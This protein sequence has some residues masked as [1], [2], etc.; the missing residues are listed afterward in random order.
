MSQDYTQEELSLECDYDRTYI[1]KI[2][3]GSKD[4]SMEA[5][6]RI[7]EVLDVPASVLFE[8]QSEEGPLEEGN[9]FDRAFRNAD[10][11]IL[12]TDPSGQI[13]QINETTLGFTGFSRDDLVGN[14]VLETSLWQDYET[15]SVMIEQGIQQAEWGNSYWNELTVTDRENDEYDLVIAISPV[16]INEIDNPEIDLVI[17]EGYID[18]Q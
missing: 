6:V 7:A 14:S 3:R 13:L 1:G 8:T 17:V 4:P 11:F 15:D 16:Q 2:E 18:P 5:I 12:I 10:H 9:F